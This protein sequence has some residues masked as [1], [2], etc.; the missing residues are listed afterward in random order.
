MVID[1]ILI[2]FFSIFLNW[3]ISLHFYL[4]SNAQ[5]LKLRN[6]LISI[7]VGLGI[8]LGLFIKYI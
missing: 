3:L 8:F 6:Q 4:Q 5:N 7:C 2:L 1:A